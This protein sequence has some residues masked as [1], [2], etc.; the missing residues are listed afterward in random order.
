M[1]GK[2]FQHGRR[3]FGGRCI[4]YQLARSHANRNDGGV[5][6]SPW[7]Q[8]HSAHCLPSVGLPASSSWKR[9]TGRP[10]SP[11]EPKSHG[12]T[13]QYATLWLIFPSPPR[14][15][16]SVALA[17]LK[18]KSLHACDPLMS[19]LRVGV[20]VSLMDMLAASRCW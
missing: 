17:F 19:L 20:G 3:V 7:Y 16:F 15:I 5:H 18:V 9:S 11:P 13:K 8:L 6:S 14:H 10:D 4:H 1:G 12:A 2:Y